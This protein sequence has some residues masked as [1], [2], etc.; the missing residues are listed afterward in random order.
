LKQFIFR[1]DFINLLLIQ[2]PEFIFD[3]PAG[4]LI[5]AE[6]NGQQDNQ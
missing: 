2:D 6:R 5:K 3:A 1:V 4:I